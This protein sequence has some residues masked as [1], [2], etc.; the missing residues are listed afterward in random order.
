MK[1]VI[2]K[3][4]AAGLWIT[5]FEFLR[6]ELLFKHYWIKHFQSIGLSFATKPINGILWMLW[7]FGLA[8]LIYRI[9]KF[10][11]FRETLLLAW[12]SAF[13]MM[14]IVAYNLQ[15]LPLKLLFVAIP[16]SL[17][18]IT[19]AQIIIKYGEIAR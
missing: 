10:F 11:S 15:V 18:E 6:N 8:Y 5:F 13:A 12:I 2:L 7:S 4:T 14:W 16:L 1:R 17:L 3:V 19:V 9:A